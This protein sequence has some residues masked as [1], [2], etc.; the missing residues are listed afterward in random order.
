VRNF[1]F[2]RSNKRISEYRTRALNKYD[3]R[4]PQRVV[5]NYSFCGFPTNITTRVRIKK[6][7]DNRLIISIRIGEVIVEYFLYFIYIY[8]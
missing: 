1:I 2:R 4:A 7:I 6:K 3:R 8:F 5:I